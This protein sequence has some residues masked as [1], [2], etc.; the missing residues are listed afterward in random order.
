MKIPTLSIS[1]SLLFVVLLT[2]CPT[3]P[4]DKTS[5][6]WL[7]I[8]PR[9]NS[10]YMY[11]NHKT[12]NPLIKAIL[13]KAGQASSD[14]EAILDRTEKSY[15]SVLL[16]PKADPEISLVLLGGYPKGY[17]HG[18]LKKNKEWQQIE[19]SYTYFKNINTPLQIAIPKAY[20]LLV[21]NNNI[22]TMLTHYEG[23]RIFPLAEDIDLD[24]DTSDLLLFFPLGLENDMADKLKIDWRKISIQ[25]IWITGHSK[26]T[27]FVF[28]AVFLIANDTGA[29]LFSTIFKLTLISLLREI[30][31]A[32]AGERLKNVQVLIEGTK[33][34]IT[35][36]YL[37]EEELTGVV[38][39]I[40]Q[41]KGQD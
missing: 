25:E 6:D 31:V 9:G 35:N 17:I 1:L 10:F 11:L 19:G 38:A 24:I 2:G 36:F 37:S 26:D 3:I 40:L 34:K 27:G 33:V 7:G 18:A 39:G 32:S 4:V 30:D 15:M 5:G 23:A 41:K 22:G 13:K 14:I 12:T 16:K 29:R 20:M 8:L 21:S 28:S